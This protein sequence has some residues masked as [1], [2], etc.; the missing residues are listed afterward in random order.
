MNL[1]GAGVSTPVQPCILAL[2]SD[3]TTQWALKKR[4]QQ[5]RKFLLLVT[6][7]GI[8]VLHAVPEVS[9]L[10]VSLGALKRM[11]IGSV[12][13]DRVE[14]WRKIAYVMARGIC[15]SRSIWTWTS[16]TFGAV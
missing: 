1:C 13:T 2:A 11:A 15:C 7:F 5:G 14:R 3:L 8:I 12:E 16:L 9:V 4:F 10:L 6:N